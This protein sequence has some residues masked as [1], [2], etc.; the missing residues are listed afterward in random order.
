MTPTPAHVEEARKIIH[1]DGVEPGAVTY[2][3][4]CSVTRPCGSCQRVVCPL[5][6]RD[7]G[8]RA[9]ETALED[10]AFDA[11]SHERW[12]ANKALAHPAV[13]RVRGGRECTH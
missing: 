7:E 13:A 12:R 5:Y 10:I 4:P 6:A 1:G 3:G 9:A 2:A 8:L 11:G